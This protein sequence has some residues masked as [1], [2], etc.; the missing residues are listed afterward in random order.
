MI[1]HVALEVSPEHQEACIE[2]YG[3]LGFREVSPPASLGERAAWLER[4]GSQIHLLRSEQPTALPEGHAAVV[5]PDYEETLAALRAAGHEPDPRT[6][7]W[8][9][10]RAFVRDPAGH[11]V[12]LMQFPPQPS[13]GPL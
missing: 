1:H 2:F 12:E 6:A 11:R 10:A 4:E 7:H 8:G 9:S 13:A 3:L 5:V